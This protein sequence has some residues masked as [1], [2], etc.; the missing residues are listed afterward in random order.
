M[1][2]EAESPGTRVAAPETAPGAEQ[3]S[4]GFVSILF[5]G[6]V[7]EGLIAGPATAFL[8]DLQIEQIIAATVAGRE[9][10]E[11]KPYFY[12]PLGDLATINYRHEVF[13]DLGDATVREAIDSF[14]RELVDVRRDLA[15]TT[16][17]RDEH[18]RQ[19]M[20]VEAAGVYC[21]A[22]RELNQNLAATA[23]ASQGLR[24]FRDYLAGYV[25][26]SEFEEMARDAE[27]V[28]DALGRVR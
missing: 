27:Q 12:L 1:F 23:P 18:Q 8:A 3:G 15:L 9:Q 10:Y 13:S 7:P 14:A 4:C 25:N 28:T 24:K 20:V 6:G 11:L 22:V 26:S 16:G 21:A 17:F 5:P 2:T 19:A